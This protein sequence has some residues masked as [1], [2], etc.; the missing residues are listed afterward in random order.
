MII[1][2]MVILIISIILF[3]FSVSNIYKK[4]TYNEEIKKENSK[5]QK[6]N[7]NLQWTR[8]DLNNKCN[9]LDK[10]INDKIEELSRANQRLNNMEQNVQ[11]SFEN[12]CDI[13][14]KEYNRKEQEYNELFEKLKIAFDNEHEKYAAA[15][16]EVSKNLDIIKQTRAA[17]IEA[18]RKEKLIKENKKHFSLNLDDMF[19]NDIQLLERIK[20][21]FSNPRVISMLI[22]QTYFRDIMNDLCNYILGNKIVCG[23]YKITNQITDECYIGQSV[24]IRG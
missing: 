7:D 4:Y 14:D 5:L 23:I 19:K 18:Q 10:A 11:N 9:N 21:D 8:E 1:I 12:Y 22:W 3:T 17:A 16:D 15:I 6:I 20:K 2:S 24:N 13:L